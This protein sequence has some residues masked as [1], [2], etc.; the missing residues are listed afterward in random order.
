M[1]FKSTFADAASRD[2]DLLHPLHQA[3][4]AFDCIDG[5]MG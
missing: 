2:T 4:V 3:L 1:G 5:V